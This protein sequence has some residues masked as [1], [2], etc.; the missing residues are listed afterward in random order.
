MEEPPPATDK[1]R[2]EIGSADAN[3]FTMGAIEDIADNYTQTQMIGLGI[4]FI[5]LPIVAVALRIWAKLLGKRRIAWDDYLICAGMVST[6]VKDS[7]RRKRM[8]DGP[9]V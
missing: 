4:G 2:L 1:P 5:I 9:F 3:K 7:Y 6:I 8:P